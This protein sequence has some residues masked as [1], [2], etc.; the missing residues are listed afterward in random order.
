MIIGAPQGTYPGGLTD[1]PPLMPENVTGLIYECPLSTPGSCGGL[2]GSS[3][4][5]SNNDRRLFDGDRKSI[6]KIC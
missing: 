1:L 2:I 6:N 4:N 3:N 5:I